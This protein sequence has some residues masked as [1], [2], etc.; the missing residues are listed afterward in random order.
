MDLSA[1][2][3]LAP[4]NRLNVP[5]IRPNHKA[6][7][8]AFG[9]DV[10]ILQKFWKDGEMT[11]AQAKEMLEK[12]KAGE[13]YELP[14]ETEDGCTKTFTLDPDMVKDVK[15]KKVGVR[16]Y[17]PSVIEPSFGIGRILYS[18]LE[19]SFYRR[20]DD[21][22][23][24]V[25]RLPSMIAPHKAAVFTLLR[26]DDA[27]NSVVERLEQEFLELGMDV[28]SDNS[29]TTSIGKKYSRADEIGI[30]FNIT[31][32]K[33]QQDTVTVRERDTTT[34]TRIPVREVVRVVHG[35]VQGFTTWQEVLDKYGVEAAPVKE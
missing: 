35:L 23:R 26:G 16:R 34:Q 20:E 25:L 8:A 6:L 13:S 4:E 28:T 27:T 30:P 33:Q 7:M 5:Q 18:V 3:D 11:E 19:H 12:H 17:I 9:K 31:V 2:V 15:W 10:R 29:G 21:P 14:V 24:Q 1:S 22:A 32:E